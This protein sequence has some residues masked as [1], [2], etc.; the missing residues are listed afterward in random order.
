MWARASY[1]LRGVPCRTFSPV[2]PTPTSCRFALPISSAPA[3]RSSATAG[4][5]ATA[6]RRV[7][8]CT[9][10]ATRVI[11]VLRPRPHARQE[12]GLHTWDRYHV[13]SLAML[14]WMHSLRA[15]CYIC[16]R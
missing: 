4:V 1:G 16:H 5:S 14:Q 2:M 11:S 9:G 15:L 12:K 10:H 8:S 7:C 3:A 6:A 13:F